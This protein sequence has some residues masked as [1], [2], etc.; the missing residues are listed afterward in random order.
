MKKL[1]ED[2]AAK[3]KAGADFAALAKQ[4]SEDDTNNT[5]GGDLDFFGRGADG[6]GVRR[7]SAFAMQPGQISDPVKTSFGYHVD[8]A[9]R[10]AGRDVSGRWPK[11]RRRSRTRSSGSARRTKRSGPPTTSPRS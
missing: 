9:D 3:A 7:R 11:C 10:E 6:A 1:A 4:Y 5:K 2:L 8:Q